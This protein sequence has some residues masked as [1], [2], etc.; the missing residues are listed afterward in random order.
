MSSQGGPSGTAIIN[1]LAEQVVKE[2]KIEEEEV[3]KQ[4]TV[5]K[6]NGSTQKLNPEEIKMRLKNLV[7]GLAVEQ[8]NIDLVVNK[9]LSYIY[10]GNLPSN[11]LLPCLINLVRYF[12]D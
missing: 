2:E 9:V 3:V 1:R 12:D 6:R 11:F 8:L 7:D 5:T 4:K 10:D